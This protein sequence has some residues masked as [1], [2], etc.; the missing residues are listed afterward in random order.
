LIAADYTNVRMGLELDGTQNCHVDQDVTSDTLKA[1]IEANHPPPALAAL[2]LDKP[3]PLAIAGNGVAYDTVILSDS[4]GSLAYNKT[5]KLK[6]PSG[7]Y[8]PVNGDAFTLNAQ[9]QATVVF[10][11]CTGCVG[12]MTLLFFYESGEAVSVPLLIR[13]GTP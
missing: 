3:G 12:E 6:V 1:A 2:T 11:P 10:G 13:F 5:V 4:R 7:A 8:L 9:G